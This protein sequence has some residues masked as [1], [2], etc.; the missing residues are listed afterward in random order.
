MRIIQVADYHLGFGSKSKD[1]LWS[2]RKTLKIAK[3]ISCDMIF[4]LGDLFDNRDAISLESLYMA[5]EIFQ[6]S[7]SMGIDW[8]WFPGNHDMHMKHNWN[9][10]S[11]LSINKNVEVINKTATLKMDG[12]D[13]M[14][15]PYIHDHA[16]YNMVLTEME[17]KA[18]PN[19]ENTIL[20][21]HVGTNKA[22]LNSCFMAKNWSDTDLTATKFK[23]IYTGHYHI[24][25]QVGDNTW[26]IGSPIPLRSEEGG[27]PHGIIVYDTIKRTHQ[28]VNLMALNDKDRPADYIMIKYDELEQSQNVAKNHIRILLEEPISDAEKS[29]IRERLMNHE[30]ALSVRYTERKQKEIISSNN[31]ELKHTNVRDIFSKFLTTRKI[32]T[33]EYNLARLNELN[34]EIVE[35][36]MA[37]IA[38][39]EAD[40]SDI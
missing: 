38:E 14:I 5:H 29:I 39:K 27:V 4:G 26:Y 34:N 12:I 21:T 13:F 22:R 28:F 30:G 35:E 17:Q 15:L 10:N 6:E 40:L 19:L 31:L 33:N 3:Q 24:H 20:L 32:E 37:I 18:E 23:R 36:T 25:Q 11:L 8:M 2:A 9:K 7:K 1:V 16:G